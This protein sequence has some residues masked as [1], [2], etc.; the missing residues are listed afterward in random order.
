MSNLLDV[1][2]SRVRLRKGQSVWNQKLAEWHASQRH[3][4]HR[5]LVE[6]HP[7]L[8][9]SLARLSFPL[10]SGTSSD[11]ADM[12]RRSADLI[13][14]LRRFQPR[15]I[16]ELGSG[17]T[18][19]VMAMWAKLN[20]ASLSSVEENGA[21]AELVQSELNRFNLPGSI[22][23]RPT[24]D[25]HKIGLKYCD[26]PLGSSDFV[27]VDGPSGISNATYRRFA[28]K[29]LCFDIL[30]HLED[31]SRPKTIVVDGRV[32]TVLAISGMRACEQYSVSFGHAVYRRLG[33]FHSDSAILQRHSI[34]SLV[35]NLPETE[36]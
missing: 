9:N 26:F 22:A 2:S 16:C 33:S 24:S 20:E 31:G 36:G 8:P 3:G 10:P 17:R 1:I 30:H 23:I 6:L 14:I 35:E 34:F 11:T 27:Y 13:A 21:W 7:D 32:D 18:T 15:R 5:T 25:V 28:R 4:D 29:G 19:L 12:I